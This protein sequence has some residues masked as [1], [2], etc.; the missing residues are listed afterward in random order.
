VIST[1]NSIKTIKQIERT[2]KGIGVPL[3][4][5]NLCSLGNTSTFFIGEKAIGKGTIIKSVKPFDVDPKYDMNMYSINILTL[6]N[7][8]YN[9]GNG[10]NNIKM[11]WRVDEWSVLKERH[12][13]MFLTLGS[14]LITDHN[15][16]HTSGAGVYAKMKLKMQNIVL[17]CLVGI[18]PFK[19]ARLLSGFESGE[20]WTALTSDRF[21]KLCLINPLR[22][23]TVE[24]AP[25]YTFV[26]KLNPVDV[27]KIDSQMTIAKMT[28][29]GQVSDQRLETFAK[30]MLKAY[31][32]YEGYE[33]VTT[34]AE[35]EFNKLFG[36]YLELFGDFTF[37]DSLDSEDHF[38][39]GAYRLFNAV[40]EHDGYPLL[41]LIEFF[42][43]YNKIGH[44]QTYVND[45]ISKYK[46]LEKHGLVKLVQN[47][48]MKFYLSD[49]VHD[50]FDWYRSL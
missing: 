6:F 43:L 12:R 21:L 29:K 50:Y 8:F 26:P 49:R 25:D 39:C 13:E 27:I 44:E 35:I 37:M 11:M 5:A 38:S 9:E 15:Y 20:N 18:Q 16:I 30:R 45:M 22:S 33:T 48:P 31:C 19:F 47:S 14:E 46:L 36:F 17:V 40:S 42:K 32:K 24:T 1:E 23:G 4:F 10:V 28:F 3:L 7:D 41:D 2:H 34:R